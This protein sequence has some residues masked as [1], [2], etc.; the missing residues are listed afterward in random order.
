MICRRSELVRPPNGVCAIQF[1]LMRRKLLNVA[2]AVLLVLLIGS[3]GMWIRSYFRC[4]VVGR[5]QWNYKPEIS[6][7]ELTQWFARVD[8][9]RV[10]VSRAFTQK[11]V[12][13]LEYS[14]K[15]Y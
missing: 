14:S 11:Y 13:R 8:S 6:S 10:I 15:K 12:G 4:A 9:G 3:T 2:I 1:T 5:F 7:E